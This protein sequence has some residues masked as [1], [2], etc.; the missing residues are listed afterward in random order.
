MKMSEHVL[1]LKL[2][3]YFLVFFSQHTGHTVGSFKQSCP[4]F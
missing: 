3:I 1:D 2:A 4:T